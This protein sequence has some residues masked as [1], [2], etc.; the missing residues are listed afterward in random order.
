V[1]IGWVFIQKYNHISNFL[2]SNFAST[3]KRMIAKN[4]GSL[5]EPSLT[6][7]LSVVLIFSFIFLGGGDTINQDYIFPVIDKNSNEDMFLAPVVL[8][9][10]YSDLLIAQSN[11]IYA[12]A[13]L[14]YP[15]TQILATKSEQNKEIISYT[16]EAGDSVGAIA[17]KFN[18]SSNTIIWANELTN[19]KLKVGTDLIILPVSGVFH[20]VG[21]NETVASIAKKYKAKTEDINE[22]NNLDEDSSINLGDVLIVPGGEKPQ[23]QP[24]VSRAS[25]SGFIAP[26][27]GVISQRLHATNAVD[28]ANACGT[29]IYASAAGT[30]QAVGYHG[31]GGNYI[32]LS[33]S[34]G[35]TTYYGHLS[36]M[37]V[38]K[39]QS[40][41]Q[42]S[43]IGYMGNTGYTIGATG[44]HVH[45]EVR[46]GT[47]PFGA[48]RLGHRF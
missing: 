40:V 31:V 5:R 41:S 35:T 27:S 23:P 34:N 38:S 2:K 10:E 39:G 22:F 11:T 47:N 37:L 30:V 4:K 29:P 25:F 21:N 16:V 15:T 14:Y 1:S 46:G 36:R 28:I 24:A 9:E 7:R 8:S 18:I 3:V 26:A 32:K 12:S 48:Y 45:F 13:P 42:G 33:H 19:T 20:I 43:V 17:E 44:C 6:F